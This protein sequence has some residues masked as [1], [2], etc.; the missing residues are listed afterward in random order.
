MNVSARS[1][2]LRLRYAIS[3]SSNNRARRTIEDRSNSGSRRVEMSRAM[4][5]SVS[6]MVDCAGVISPF[7]RAS[8]SKEHLLSKEWSVYTSHF[9]VTQ[10][11]LIAT[12][13][14]EDQGDTWSGVTAS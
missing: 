1:E 5:V 11:T 10:V 12:R 6:A 7:S 2:S 3:V 8:V 13:G 14:S 4:S 9:V